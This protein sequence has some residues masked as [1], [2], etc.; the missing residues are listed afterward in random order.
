MKNIKKTIKESLPDIFIYY[1]KVIQIFPKFLKAEFKNL[2]VKFKH[3]EFYTDEETVDK[4]VFERKS[5][6]RFGDGELIWM[7]G[8]KLDSFQEYSPELSKDLIKAFCSKNPNLL[9]GIPYG[10]QN[11]KKCNL[12]AKM[13]WRIIKCDFYKRLERFLDYKTIYSNASITRPYIDYRDRKFS[14]NSFD[15]LRRIWDRKDIVIIEGK[16]SKLGLGNDL[17]DNANSIKRII[18]PAQNAYEKKDE[19]KQAVIKNVDK[20]SLIIAALGPTA[21]ILASELCDEGFQVV[22][23]G[24]VDIEYMWYK[25]HSILRDEV[26]GKQV[27]ESGNKN[28][29]QTYDVDGDYLNSIMLRIE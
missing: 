5:L 23:T 3:I 1:Y 16:Y 8:G 21:T 20:N 11:S 6:S 18:C 27:N 19:I 17:F 12:Y 9:I 25:N 24:H 22:D 14:K 26:K 4:I 13:H 15:N 2:G 28:C 29:D 10:I 7:T